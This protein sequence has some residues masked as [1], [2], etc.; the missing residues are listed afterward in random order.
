MG[1]I[2][3]GVGLFSGIDSA[4]LIDQLIAAQSRPQILAQ[5]RVI[6]LKSQQA[7]YLDI[8][9]RLSAFKT[10]AAS[11]RLGNIFNSTSV[12]SSNETALTAT[13]T[14]SAVPGSYNFIVDQLV[15]T[16]QQLSR[17]F[18]DTDS[19][20]IGLDSLTFESAAARL[21]SNT[22][23]ADLNNGDGINRGKITVNG[24]EVDLSRVGSMQEVLDAISEV[25]GVSARVENDKIVIQGVSSISESTGSGVLESLGLDGSITLNGA[26]DA[27]NELIG[28]SVYGINSNT[29]LGSLNDGRGV[30]S[31]STLGVGVIDF[32]INID[33]TNVGVRIGEIEGQLTDDEGE[34]MFTD[35]DPPVAVNGVI[36]GAV[37]SLGG[38]I[39]RINNALDEAG[40]SEASASINQATGGIDITDA[41]GREIIIE[42]LTVGSTTYTTASDLGIVGTSPGGNISGERILAGLN[43]RLL[44]SL[45]GGSG[46]GLED[47]DGEIELSTRD[48]SVV[49]VD[50]LDIAGLNDIN[51]LINAINTDADN[52]DGSGNQRVTASI[53]SNGTGI[54]IVDNTVGANTFVI[55]GSGGADDAAV[56]LGVSGSF[57]D[58]ISR[59]ENLQ[60]AY[61]SAA[62][63]VSELN[64][65]QGIGVGRFEIVDTYG[66]IKEVNITSNEK[67]V[68][69]V[70]R[71]INSAAP[72]VIAR[73]NDNG[74]GIIIE[75]R[76]N[77]AV[78][79][80]N[81]PIPTGGLAIT[82]T[83][84]SGSVA[85][86]LGILG[87]ATDV[88]EDSFID[89]SFEKV[90]EFEP[91]ATLDD[92]RQAINGSGVG[93]SAS[94]INTGTGTAPF[95]L[96]LTSQRS[97]ED[98]RYLIDT[99]SF[100]L[101]LDTLDEGNNSRVFF[102]STDPASAVLLSSSS[103]Q[104]DG[105]I[106]GVTIDLNNRSDD[107]IEVAVSRDTSAIEGKIT[108]F[109]ESFNAIIEAIDFRSRYDEET[110]TKG[111]LLGDGTVLNLRNSLYS[112]LNRKNDGFTS[113]F[114]SLTQAGIRVGSGGKLEFNATTF[115][116]AYAENPQAV[117]DLFT[118][119][120][121][122][123][124][125]DDD[126]NT[127]DEQSFSE[128][129]VIGQLEEF[130]DSYV[131]S[132]GGVLQL[133]SDALDSQIK[134]QEE[135][136][137][138][139]QAS[140]DNK[141]VILGR[142]FLAMEQAIGSFQTQGASLSQLAALG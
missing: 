35:D 91:D 49:V 30:A 61:I 92:I 2:T 134:L 105:I 40:Y 45:N 11:F 4:S 12:T 111:V 106:Q 31:R 25:S 44:S 71:A 98:G 89:G 51:D 103:N 3:T 129:S 124:N 96:S 107:P 62:T 139:I 94:I 23:L 47:T 6:Q 123:S 74:D 18:S 70:L 75:E 14:T 140:L 114:D 80:E 33:G 66:Q 121:I 42:D 73:I 110:E 19:S 9:S 97:G 53:N 117:E 122:E 64:N 36:D 26:G 83:N 10:A 13:S 54:Q 7:A 41:N 29:P 90:I 95:R 28:T 87:T 116:E 38:V 50:G 8:N 142:Q 131:S 109:V 118:R 22:D 76:P 78:D 52:I 77:G 32:N 56:A 15:S 68:G 65:G 1:G 58:G 130:A 136:I 43:T 59:G 63:P 82:I 108:E 60:L 120:T 27:D 69:D 21:D 46:L 34:L 100:D 84:K 79:D 132:L 127:I 104:L 99:G 37:S 126:P 24:T 81:N 138:S 5:Q 17:G 115:R 57:S 135:R 86:K 102:G 93:V 16:Q 141:R 113:D 119:Q 67:T 20:T 137:E 128:L 55:A 48:G 112:T 133:R 39:E 72:G 85:T 101:G 125:D 88:G